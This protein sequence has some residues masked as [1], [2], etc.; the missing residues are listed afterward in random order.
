VQSQQ[1]QGQ[2]RFS[3]AGFAHHA[4]HFAARHR[5]AHAIEGAKR[6]A[7][8]VKFRGQLADL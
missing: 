3:A 4:Q 2:R 6:T 5:K 7:I 1:R 8:A